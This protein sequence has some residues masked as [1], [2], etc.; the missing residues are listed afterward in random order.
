MSS[1]TN[2]EADL[3]GDLESA[4]SSEELSE[5]DG[6]DVEGVNPDSCDDDDCR[7]MAE[8]KQ[9]FFSPVPTSS[10][11]NG[12]SCRLNLISKSAP[13]QQILRDSCPS[14]SA[15]VES[16]TPKLSKKNLLVEKC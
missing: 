7:G 15:P 16:S 6:G 10:N 12:R 5:R 3:S 4:P 1:L 13:T 2:A 9:R 8:K 11:G 14:K